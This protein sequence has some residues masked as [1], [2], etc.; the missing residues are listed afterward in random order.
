MEDRETKGKKMAVIVYWGWKVR[1]SLKSLGRQS[2]EFSRLL[3]I[4]TEDLPHP[5]SLL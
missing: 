3:T 4:E 5:G 1:E 2:K